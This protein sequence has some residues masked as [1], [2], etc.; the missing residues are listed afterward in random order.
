MTQIVIFFGSN[1]FINGS[2]FVTDLMVLLKIDEIQ[3]MAGCKSVTR[4]TDMFADFLYWPL[5]TAILSRF[6]MED[7]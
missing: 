6:A 3:V 5:S 2:D 7:R 1:M 4:G